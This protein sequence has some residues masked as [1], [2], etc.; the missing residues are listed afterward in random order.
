MK[1]LF[2]VIKSYVIEF[3]FSF[4]QTLLDP[5]PLRIMR[6]LSELLTC[7]AYRREWG[8]NACWFWLNHSKNLYVRLL[9]FSH[10]QHTHRCY[11]LIY[12][13]FPAHTVTL[14]HTIL[15]VTIFPISGKNLVLILFEHK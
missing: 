3:F 13:K 4:K 14:L 2:Q 11:K 7:S 15:H 8:H 10:K 6:N 12:L 5:K 1:N 9:I